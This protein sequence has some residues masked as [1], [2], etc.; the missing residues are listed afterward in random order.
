MTGLQTISST[1]QQRTHV[2]AVRVTGRIDQWP[3]CDA[4]AMTDKPRH[5][6]RANTA[7]LS[8]LQWWI[9]GVATLVFA[10]GVVLAVTGRTALAAMLMGLAFLVNIFT[11]VSATE[12]GTSK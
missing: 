7:A 3:L 5:R 8:S 1:P 6:I 2:A 10:F 11:V 9:V 4:R 12:R